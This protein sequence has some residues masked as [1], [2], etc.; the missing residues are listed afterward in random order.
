M[1]KDGA[2]VSDKVIGV[3]GTICLNSIFLVFVRPADTETAVD[4]ELRGVSVP[5]RPQRSAT[6]PTSDHAG[7]SY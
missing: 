6:I 4:R 3:I 1:R 7:A 5:Q 2:G